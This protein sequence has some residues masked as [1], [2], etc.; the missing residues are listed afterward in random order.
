MK[1]I[2]Q[3]ILFALIGMLYFAPTAS[4]QSQADNTRFSARLAISPYAQAV[5]NDSYTFI[6]VSHPSLDSALTQIGVVVEA[7]GMTT[8]I[9]TTAGRAVVFTVDAGE[10]HRVFIVNQG[11]A[12]INS[13]NASFTDSRTHL[14]PTVDSAQ[15]GAVRVTSVSERPEQL[16]T[17][18]N[19]TVGSV[20]KFDNLAQLSIWGIVYIESGGAGFAMEFIGDMQDSTLGG[21]LSSGV[22]STLGNDSSGGNNEELP[23]PARG[24]N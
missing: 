14:I 10:T 2:K 21:N 23:R 20:Q 17:S 13:S 16:A 5:P 1:N 18:R 11:N 4:G 15:F 12:T 9:N 8:T 3:L 6:G 22:G 7:I 24:I 19:V